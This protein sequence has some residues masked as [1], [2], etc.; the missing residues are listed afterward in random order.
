MIHSLSSALNEQEWIFVGH[1]KLRICW[2]DRSVCNQGSATIIASGMGETHR[3]FISVVNC[4]QSL[5]EPFFTYYRVTEATCTPLTR[6]HQVMVIVNGIMT[7]QTTS[8]NRRK[9]RKR[10]ARCARTSGNNKLLSV[11]LPLVLYARARCRWVGV[12]CGGARC[13]MCASARE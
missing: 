1:N 10:K 9:D 7:K 4:V 13:A 3:K 11:N 6:P 12:R 2:V 5:H 8:P